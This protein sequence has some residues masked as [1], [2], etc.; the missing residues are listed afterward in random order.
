MEMFEHLSQYGE[1]IPQWLAGDAF[2]LSSF[3][4]SRTVVYPGAGSDGHAIKI[5]NRSHSAHC[6]VYIDQDYRAEQICE[7]LTAGPNETSTLFIRGYHV[8]FQ[9]DY[10]QEVQPVDG[11]SAFHLCVYERKADYGD[12]HGAKRIALLLVG[13][14]AHATYQRLYGRAFADNPPFGV[15]LQDHG[16][17]GNCSGYT[18]GGPRSPMVETARANGWPRFIVV[19]DDT[20]PWPCFVGIAG[21]NSSGGGM[22]QNPRMLYEYSP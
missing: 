11:C 6:F 17:G 7:E 22:H 14:E 9:H 15:L 18:F 20:D 13:A 2:S 10:S 12:D 3:F 4:K 5:F 16:F 21:V 19:G 1:P 8:I